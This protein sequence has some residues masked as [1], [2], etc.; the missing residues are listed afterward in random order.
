MKDGQYCIGVLSDTH[1]LLRPEVTEHL[2]GCDAI[3]HGGDINRQEILDELAGIA[4][5]YVVRGN[6]DKDWA[7][8]IPYTLSEEICGLRVFM[9]HKKKE[10]P[11]ETGGAQLV[12]YGHSHK[13][14]EAVKDGV[15]FLNPGSCGP[16]RFNQA[17]TMALVHVD[18]EGAIRAERIE[19][20]HRSAE[21]PDQQE[22]D[23]QVLDRDA[24]G[25]VE[26][27]VSDINKGRSSAKIAKKYGISPELADTINRMY[28]THPGVTVDGILTKMGL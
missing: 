5:L 26:K 11:E 17:I 3:L 10:I 25:L 2:A 18:G 22:R 1:G 13:Y 6:N 23:R 4:P 8:H 28:L 9:T 15:L 21:S 19:I 14:E 16:R 7:E 20:P 12:V 27:V 24:R